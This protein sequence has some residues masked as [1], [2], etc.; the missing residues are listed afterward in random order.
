MD[1]K[2]IFLKIKKYFF[3][4]L[5]SKKYFEKQRYILE[6]FFKYVFLNLLKII[7]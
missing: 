4:I 7:F 1:V 2:N 6:L 5:L 3:N